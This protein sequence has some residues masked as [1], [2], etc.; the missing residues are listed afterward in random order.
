[1]AAAAENQRLDAIRNAAFSLFAER[2]Y[3]STTVE[4]I[5]RSAEVGVG[6]IY[7]RWADKQTLAN[8]L[9][10]FA[11]DALTCHEIAQV[12]PKN[13]KGQFMSMWL[14][15][16]DF[17]RA[18]PD[19]FLFLEGQPHEAYIDSRTLRR[20]HEK[21]RERAILVRDLGF[22]VNADVAAAMVYGT[23]IQCVRMDVEID[24]LDVGERLWRALTRS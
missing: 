23:V 20:R 17:A 9:F 1:M 15:T 12:F 2:G 6:T 21:E 22:T 14:H 19:M 16:H 5:A 24:A 8:D 18:H 10:E 11:L 3:G 4:D 13:A 7:R